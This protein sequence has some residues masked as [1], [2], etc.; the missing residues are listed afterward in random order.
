MSG[1]EKVLSIVGSKEG[2]AD[3]ILGHEKT[4]YNWLPWKRCNYTVLPIANSF[5]NIHLIYW[6]TLVYNCIQTNYQ[7]GIVTWN[8]ICIWIISIWQEYLIPYDCANE[9]YR[10]IKSFLIIA[11]LK[12]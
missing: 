7:T 2:H 6:M 3:S 1:K 9:Y 8:Y 11:T 5:C 10:W 4:P 12:I